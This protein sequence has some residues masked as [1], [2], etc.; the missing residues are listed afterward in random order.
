MAILPGN[1]LGM[2]GGGQLGRMFVIAARTMGYEVI[3]LDP[4]ADSPA[5]K[6][7]SEHLKANY[8]DRRALD[9][10]AK[11]CAVIST[12]FENIPAESLDYL[13]NYLPVHPSG[14][15]LRI[16]QNRILEKQ[17]FTQQGINIAPYVAIDSVADLAQAQNFEYPAILKI[18]TLGYDGKGQYVC[19]SFDEFRSAYDQIGV[20]TCVLEKKVNLVRE[21]SV[22]LCRSEAGDIDCF[23]VAE[24]EHL[25]G[26][27]DLSVVPAGLSRQQ[28]IEVKQAASRIAHGLNYCGVLAVE[29][30]ISS[31]DE[32][33]VNEM[34][35]RPHN[36]G[37]FTI[38]ACETSQFEQQVR[39]MCGIPSGSS[40]QYTPVVMWNVLGDIW[41]QGGTPAWGEVLC[42]QNMKLHL[43]GKTEARAGRKMGHINCLATNTREA[44]QRLAD[45]KIKLNRPDR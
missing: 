18:A 4:D 42:Q 9:H 43:Y 12:E 19:N 24:N 7:A 6:M 17:F 35:P 13:A 11:H 37:H 21:V 26:I 8:D 23:P 27:L 44:R 31:D 34:A 38:D 30:F 3:V 33:L 41:P 36:S 14:S 29:F 20:S 40:R 15:A 5:G 32:V 2:L 25:N 1:T 45:L 28:S 10:L 16:A 39:M 22:I